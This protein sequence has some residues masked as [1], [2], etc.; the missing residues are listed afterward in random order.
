[1]EKFDE[2]LRKRIVKVFRDGSHKYTDGKMYKNVVNAGRVIKQR[3][4]GYY[5]YCDGVDEDALAEYCKELDIDYTLYV[6]KS[7][8]MNVFGTKERVIVEIW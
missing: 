1:M 7:R 5:F 8:K 4:D 6:V 2:N 3:G